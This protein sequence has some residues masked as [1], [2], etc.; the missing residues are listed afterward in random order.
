MCEMLYNWFNSYLDIPDIIAGG[1]NRWCNWSVPPSCYATS[2]DDE[3][4]LRDK[5]SELIK[6]H[7][8]MKNVVQKESNLH[9]SLLINGIFN[10]VKQTVF[11]K[12]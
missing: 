4:T 6:M 10:Q 1:V 12:Q 5:L 9:A 3:D 7:D 2:D 11:G 8:S